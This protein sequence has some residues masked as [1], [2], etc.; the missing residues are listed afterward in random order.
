[1]MWLLPLIISWLSEGTSRH[2]GRNEGQTPGVVVTGPAGD[3]IFGD[4]VVVL[5]MSVVNSVGVPVA[6]G[7]VS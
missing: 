3:V 7:V 2:F 1:M 5:F 6:M 4:S